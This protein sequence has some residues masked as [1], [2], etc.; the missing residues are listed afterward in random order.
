MNQILNSLIF[1]TLAQK[2]TTSET[3]QSDGFSFGLKLIPTN[4]LVFRQT[5][6]RLLTDEKTPAV[7]GK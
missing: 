6:L 4:N 1:V 2:K 5:H 3:I 7:C